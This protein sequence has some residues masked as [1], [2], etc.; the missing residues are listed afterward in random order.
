MNYQ[1]RL[2]KEFNLL[3][4]YAKQAFN[5]NTEAFGCIFPWTILSK[6]FLYSF[7][8]AEPFSACNDEVRLPLFAQC[9]NEKIQ[10]TNIMKD[11]FFNCNKKF[12]DVDIIY[13]NIDKVNAFHPVKVLD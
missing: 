1:P 5:W 11:E 9:F 8:I 12:I 4:D 7:L 13:K 3:K 6:N 10:S 2:K